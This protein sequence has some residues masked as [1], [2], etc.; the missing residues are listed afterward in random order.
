MPLEDANLGPMREASGRYTY[1]VI[2]GALYGDDSFDVF[3]LIAAFQ[4]AEDQPLVPIWDGSNTVAG[5]DSALGSSLHWQRL[6]DIAETVLSD[7]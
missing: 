7:E 3:K 5:S 1:S 4:A 2:R 6:R